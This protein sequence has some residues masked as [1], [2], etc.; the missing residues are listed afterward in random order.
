[1][2]EKLM[3]ARA[4]A[5]EAAIRR[6][7][8]RVFKLRHN[9]GSIEDDVMRRRAEDEV[10]EQMLADLEFENI[11]SYWMDDDSDGDGDGDGGRRSRRKE[12]RN[13]FVYSFTE[14]ASR[15]EELM[16]DKGRKC[17]MDA[18][19]A[20][21]CAKGCAY[22]SRYMQCMPESMDDDGGDAEWDTQPMMYV[23]ATNEVLMDRLRKML[24][25]Y[26][27]PKVRQRVRR[28]IKRQLGRESY[29]R[30]SQDGIM[31]L[32]S[33]VQYRMK[34]R[35]VSKVLSVWLLG[36]VVLTLYVPVDKVYFP[37]VLLA[38]AVESAKLMR[39]MKDWRVALLSSMGMGQSAKVDGAVRLFASRAV[40]D[41]DRR[42][43]TFLNIVNVVSMAT[44]FLDNFA[45]IRTQDALVWCRR[46]MVS[47]H[48]AV[49]QIMGLPS[50]QML[51]MWWRIMQARGPS[52]AAAAAAE[53][54]PDEAPAP[55][56]M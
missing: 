23:L 7:D 3:K 45:A 35:S 28:Y 32:V 33:E 40:E 9:I 34:A 47:K 48:M 14:A 39:R 8:D 38:A 12:D 13:Q 49:Q 10:A 55:Y 52:P 1:M 4:A 15:M 17:A 31:G 5:R 43:V 46:W 50:P 56:I 26:S 44:Q 2:S 51:R 36:L 30:I 54:H 6:A 37:Y 11:E 22:V 19:Q 41:L 16:K 42:F 21:R 24:A 25:R 20:D 27:E 29:D 53:Q 18:T